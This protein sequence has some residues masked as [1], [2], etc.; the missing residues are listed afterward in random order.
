MNHVNPIDL[1]ILI[2]SA[3]L[4]LGL[5]AS[6]VGGRLGVPGLVLFLVIGMLA[7]GTEIVHGLQRALATRLR[8]AT[9]KRIPAWF[10]AD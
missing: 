10:L 8:R 6:K 5:L 9:P 4:L 1:P 3:L 7:A 2:V